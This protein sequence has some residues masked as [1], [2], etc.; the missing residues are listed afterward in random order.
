MICCKL[1]AIGDHEKSSSRGVGC[2][3]AT[4][5]EDLLCVKRYQTGWH[6]RRTKVQFTVKLSDYLNFTR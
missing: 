4:T 1:H 3:S 6:D 5:P 2:G